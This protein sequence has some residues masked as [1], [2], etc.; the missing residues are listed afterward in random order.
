LINWVKRKE[1]PDSNLNNYNSAGQYANVKFGK[2]AFSL[3]IAKNLGQPNSN[4][5]D[6]II[7]RKPHHHRTT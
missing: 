2:S 7:G 5:G 3:N 6:I 1:T 4:Y